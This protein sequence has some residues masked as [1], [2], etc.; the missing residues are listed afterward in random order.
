MQFAHDKMRV[1]AVVEAP[2]FVVV[3]CG[4]VRGR[5]RR[6]REREREEG[7]EGRSVAAPGRTI[8]HMGGAGEE[9]GGGERGDLTVQHEREGHE[10]EP[11]QDVERVVAE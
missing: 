1:V 3:R 2:I 9:S 8:P 7:K 4:G 6:R 11:M 10:S 5:K